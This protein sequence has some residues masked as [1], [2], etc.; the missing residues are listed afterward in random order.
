MI[1]QFYQRR[2]FPHLLNQVMQ[3]AS[4]M[5]RRRELL[6][7][8][9]G[10]VLEIGFGTG[11]NIP[12]YGNVG[13]LYALEPNPDIYLLAVERVQQAP[14]F[15]KHIQSSAEKL[16]FATASLDHVVSTWTLCSIAQLDQTLAEIYRVLKPTGTF[17]LVEHVKH[18]D[19]AKIQSLQTLLTP[20]QKRI[21]DGCHLNRDMERHLLQAKFKLIEKQYF[22]A[23]GIP[24][25]AQKMLFARA[26]KLEIPH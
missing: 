2:I 3:T 4:L 8:I 21:A 18:P 11:L 25:I 19:S 14:F 13:T 7:P 10:E 5:D 15:I 20:I 23:E 9:E 16:P 24:A 6:L 22:D 12:F 1:Y 26:Q 17:H